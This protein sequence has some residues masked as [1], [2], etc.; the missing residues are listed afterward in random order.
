MSFTGSAVVGAFGEF[1]KDEELAELGLWPMV[2]GG[3]PTILMGY[4]GMGTGTVTGREDDIG[5]GDR[6]FRKGT[7]GFLQQR[8][9]GMSES[10]G[11]VREQDMRGTLGRV[12]AISGG[13]FDFF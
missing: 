7:H 4:T 13:G 1:H 9:R 8:I 6:K 11:G 5:A 10:V 3:F 2:A 12:L